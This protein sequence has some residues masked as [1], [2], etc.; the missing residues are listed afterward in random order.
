MDIYE[1]MFYMKKIKLFKLFAGILSVLLILG[2]TACGTGGKAPELKPGSSDALILSDADYSNVNNWLSFGG[3][4]GKAVDV[5]VI[6]PTVTFS[7]DEADLPFVRLDSQIM[8][9]SAAGWIA[10]VDGIFSDSVNVYAPL[11]SQLN[12][13]MLENLKAEEFDA[14]TTSVP[15]DDIFAAFDY[16][17]T[18]INKGERP[19]ILFGHSQGGRL[20]IELA[21]TFLG[22][23][24]YYKYNKNHIIT[25]A[26]GMSVDGEEI[27][28]N[29][30]LKFSGSRDDTGVLV[31][32]N[33]T[34]PSE[35]AT[36]AYTAF[37]TWKPGALVTNPVSWEANET[38]AH[39]SANKASEV[40]Q[41]DETVKM[42][43]SY[44]NAVVDKEHCVL[45]T[46]SVD[47]SL[48]PSM[49]PQLSRFHRFDIAFY[50][51]SIKQNI[52][53]RIAAFTK[54]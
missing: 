20:V 41:P 50:Y 52:K 33:T 3:D 30:N 42:V 47:E 40:M 16:Y 34:A 7:P 22:N 45:V 25:Y 49:M 12:V 54:K 10:G 29:P 4:K 39:A 15:R 32:W 44:A 26:I 27:A 6:Y 17:L 35:V 48:Y 43:E 28:K 2:M 46:T 9:D 18:N 19:F 31:S 13:A 11:Y 5:F 53:D 8:R 21:T 23:E 37:G 24:K 1:R 36:G 51:E 14:Y 38:L